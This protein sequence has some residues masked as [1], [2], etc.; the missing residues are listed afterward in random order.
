MLSMKSL[1]SLACL[2]TLVP[3]TAQAE[4]HT[5]AKKW[6]ERTAAHY[7]QGPYSLTYSM[8]MNL[9]QQG[10]AV[11]IAAT[12]ELL[13]G[14]P[15]AQR[16]N[17]GLVMS[18]PQA[19]PEPMKMNTLIV[20]DGETIWTEV[21]NPL[22]GGKQVAKMSVAAATEQAKKVGMLGGMDPSQMDPASQVEMF[23][24]MADLKVTEISGGKVKLTGLVGEDFRD[25]FGPVADQLG[26]G[27]LTLVLSEKTGEM[28]EMSLGDAGAP[29]MTTR[30][31]NLKFL[32]AEE[33]PSGSFTY[34][35][36]EG[37]AV[38]DLASGA[39]GTGGS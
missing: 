26:D 29:L 21:D 8:D 23:G 32:K 5:D 30:F 2:M 1:A 20:N 19:M 37:A 18:M 15:K 13:Y 11:S 38:Q 7:S 10:M 33:I 27:Q 39:S 12:G 4:P 34:S 14:G 16:M 25:S 6:L 17:L 35:P 22:I 9:Q 36:P 28:L 24:K 3:A 31:E